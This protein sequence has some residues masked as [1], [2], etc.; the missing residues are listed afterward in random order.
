LHGDDTVDPTRVVPE[1]FD[2]TS[3]WRQ[4][5]DQTVSLTTLTTGNPTVMTDAT[6]QLALEVIGDDHTMLEV[7]ANGRTI[8]STIAELRAGARS[9]YV[10]GFLSPVI[11]LHR[12]VDRASRTVHLTLHDQGT[13]SEGQDWY[14]TRVR[15]VNGQYAWSSPTWVANR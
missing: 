11:Q 12:A 2:A 9:E 3:R 5:D 1:R 14:Y 6:Q 10:G 7:R 13:G 8:R 15:Q 4:I